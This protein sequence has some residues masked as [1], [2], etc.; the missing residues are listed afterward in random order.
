A[1]H[2]LRADMGKYVA[3]GDVT[4]QRSD[5]GRIVTSHTE[6]P[7]EKTTVKLYYDRDGHL[8]RADAVQDG[9][10]KAV[11]F[12]VGEKGTGIMKRGGITDLFKDLPANPVVTAGPAW[13]GALPLLRRYDAGKGGK[14]DFAGFWIDPVLG[15]EKVTYSV[16]H[17]GTDAVAVKD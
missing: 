4:D 10:R 7:D 5:D 8:A 15:L 13:T 16:E 1:L 17:K 2:Y 14:Q 11:T 9:T 6:R 3:A 12:T